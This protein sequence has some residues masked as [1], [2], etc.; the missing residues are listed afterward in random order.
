VYIVAGPE[1]APMEGHT[2]LIDNALYGLR[3]SGLCWH[4]RFSDV[5]RDTG[6]TPSKAEGDIWMREGDEVYEYIAV[7]V[8]DLLIAARNPEEIVRDYFR[9][10]DG[11]LCYG[12]KKYIGKIVNQYNKMF[13]SK[14]REYTLSDNDWLFTM[15]NIT[16]MI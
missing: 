14:P 9:E 2:L 1:F 3:S 11:T 5:L 13:G 16:W 6:F 7:Y 10:R 12:P 8:N 15:G 4:Q